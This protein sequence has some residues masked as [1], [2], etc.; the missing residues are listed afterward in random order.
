MI[1]I[2]VEFCFLIFLVPLSEIQLFSFL[3][4]YFGIVN[5]ICI[6]FGNL[7]LKLLHY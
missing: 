4:C 2:F 1:R 3:C 5:Q 6:A 7:V